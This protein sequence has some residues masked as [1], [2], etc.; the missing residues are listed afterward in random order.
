MK[1]WLEVFPS[2]PIFVSKID[3]TTPFAI[4]SSAEAHLEEMLLEENHRECLHAVCP[5]LVFNVASIIENP[6]P[7]ISIAN[8]SVV[9]RSTMIE[10]RNPVMSTGM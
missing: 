5:N 8:D 3:K 2:I 7:C 6:D 9:G 4:L 10:C 1:N